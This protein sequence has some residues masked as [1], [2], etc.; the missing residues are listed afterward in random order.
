MYMMYVGVLGEAMKAEFPH[1]IKR[2]VPFEVPTMFDDLFKNDP[3][4]IEVDEQAAREII[5]EYDVAKDISE[6]V[7]LA[8]EYIKAAKETIDI[9]LKEWKARRDAH[10]KKVAEAQKAKASR[11]EPEAAVPAKVVPRG[12]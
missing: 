1:L 7:E 11:K 9:G 12:R 4:Y 8:N 2:G 6:K 3:L 5:K 10:R